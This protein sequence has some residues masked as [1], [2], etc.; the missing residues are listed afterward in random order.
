MQLPTRGP[1]AAGYSPRRDGRPHFVLSRMSDVSFSKA[2]PTRYSRYCLEID[3][4]KF[5]EE[6]RQQLLPYLLSPVCDK[7]ASTT[8]SARASLWTRP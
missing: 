3:T 7:A 6:L 2:F 4:S 1:L 8:S 5:P